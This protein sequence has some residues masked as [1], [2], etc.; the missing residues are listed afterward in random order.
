MGYAWSRLG[1]PFDAKMVS[2][3][4]TT[5]GT[6][7]LVVSSLTKLE[8]EAGA[9]LS[10]GGGAAAALATFALIGLAGL[11]LLRL[12][13]RDYLPAVTFP[14]CGNMGM[15]LCLFAF[16]P[17]GLAFGHDGYLYVASEGAGKRGTILGFCPD[18]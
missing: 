9:V 5:V 1:Q 14:N 16:G 2:A 18:Y 3:I 7:C 17:E 15:P 11:R 10:M 13:P 8:V 6:P 12:S 4:V